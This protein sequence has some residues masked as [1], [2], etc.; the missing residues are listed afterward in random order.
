VPVDLHNFQPA[1]QATGRPM[2]EVL[3]NGDMLAEAMLQAWRE[4]GHDMILL[5]NGTAC[6]AQACGASVVYRDESAPVVEAPLIASLAEARNLQVPDPERAFPMCEV[7][8]A[9]R[10][11]S[12]EIGD[13]VWIC[14]RADQGPMDLAAQLRGIDNFMMDIALGE[15]EDLIH[16]LLDYARRVATR[17]AFALIEAGG[18]STS[19]G[20]PVSGPELLSPRHYRRYPWVHQKRMAEELRQHG[21]ILHHHICG[22]T[23]K[24]TEDFIATGAQVLEVD[25]KTAPGPIKKAALGR[26]CLLGNID[27]GLVAFG[28]PAQVEDACRELIDLWRPG[29]GFILGP[30]C[31]I[32]PDA[33]AANI[34]ALV[35]AGKKYGRY[36]N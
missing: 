33:P 11:L 18:H 15:E 26:A 29:S 12:R 28:S 30:G 16:C 21:I 35:E 25:H 5:E 32:G 1:A 9:T 27:T 10:I 19:I 2:A 23:A 31:A 24:I 22:N 3:R 6:N 8:K 7:L 17:Y 14:A 20:E 4:Y 36:G 34:H 13:K